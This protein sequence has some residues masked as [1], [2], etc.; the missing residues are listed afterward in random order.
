MIRIIVLV[1]LFFLLD[2]YANI[3]NDNDD[4]TSSML[5]NQLKETLKLKVK[6]FVL[7]IIN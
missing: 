3:S 4:K 6:L 1:F 7:I 5:S 2:I